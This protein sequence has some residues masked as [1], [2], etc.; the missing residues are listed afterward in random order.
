MPITVNQESIS[1]L[2]EKE[3]NKV[4]EECQEMANMGRSKCYSIIESSVR[5]EV[6]EKLE[7]EHGIYVL[8]SYNRDL[9]SRRMIDRINHYQH[10]IGFS[11]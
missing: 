1:L 10:E 6:I 7:K 5:H 2:I 8:I 9:P 11:W 3:V 4:V